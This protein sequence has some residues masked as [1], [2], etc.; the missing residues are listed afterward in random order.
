MTGCATQ[1]G[2]GASTARPPRPIPLASEPTPSASPLR[3]PATGD[4]AIRFPIDCVGVDG[5][6]IGP[7]TRLEEA[8][9]STNYVR[10]DHCDGRPPSA[11]RL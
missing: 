1:P 9:A 5:S 10:I 7:F 3:Y 4:R 8:W 2:P 6:D 11:G